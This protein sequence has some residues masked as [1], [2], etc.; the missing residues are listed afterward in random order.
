MGAATV[1]VLKDAW[2]KTASTLRTPKTPQLLLFFTTELLHTIISYV[3]T[4]VKYIRVT[5]KTFLFK[6]IMLMGSLLFFL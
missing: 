5:E 3:T 4:A 2:E 1:G 6:F